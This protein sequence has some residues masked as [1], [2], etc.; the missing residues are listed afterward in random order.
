MPVDQEKLNQFV[1]KFVGDLGE[2]IHGPSVLM[3][4]QL[5]L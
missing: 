1:N 3:G 5:G 4:E 2:S